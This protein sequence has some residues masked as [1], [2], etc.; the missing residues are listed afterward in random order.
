M[1]VGCHGSKWHFRPRPSVK[2]THSSAR[3]AQG[4]SMAFFLGRFC[5]VGMGQK[6]SI[7]DWGNNMKKIHKPAIWIYM[8]PCGYQ[9]FDSKSQAFSWSNELHRKIHCGEWWL[10]FAVDL[11]IDWFP[12][13]NFQAK[14]IQ[15]T[16][17]STIN[18]EEVLFPWIISNCIYTYIYLHIYRVIYIYMTY[19]YY[20]HILMYC[21]SLSM[22]LLCRGCC[23][24]LA[25]EAFTMAACY[26][27]NYDAE[28]GTGGNGGSDASPGTNW[29]SVTKV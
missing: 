27:P 1:I 2:S 17:D 26:C 22:F 28:R 4:R 20:I 12:A 10:D 14:Q 23:D 21:T 15:R 5:S 25:S 8:V 24:D 6:P 16:M 11:T 13:F 19:I 18:W 7:Y 9:G 29:W 3:D